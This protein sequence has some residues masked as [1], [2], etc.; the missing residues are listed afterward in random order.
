MIIRFL[1]TFHSSEMLLIMSGVL[2]SYPTGRAEHAT[3][4]CSLCSSL[5]SVQG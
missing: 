4:D 1:R 2:P 5:E 3:Q